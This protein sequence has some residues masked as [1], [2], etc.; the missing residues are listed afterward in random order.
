MR[1][2]L[3][4]AVAACGNVKTPSFVDAGSLDSPSL[5]DAGSLD[6]LTDA[7]SQCPIEIMT[8]APPTWR[9]QGQGPFVLAADPAGSGGLVWVSNSHIPAPAS[10]SVPFQV[11]DRITGL[12]FAAYGNGSAAGLKNIKVLYQPDEMSSWQI[13]AMGEDLGRK[14]QWGQVE[15]AKFQPTVLDVGAICWVQFD[16][17]EAGYYIG[18]VTPVIERPCL[19]SKD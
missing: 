15:F 17:T 2:L 19:R 11:G 5:V 12:V 18:M 1:I 9:A 7:P 6:S 8:P 4:L 10:F 16:V 13:L 3:L 14:A